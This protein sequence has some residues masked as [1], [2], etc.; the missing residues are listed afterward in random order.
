M[1]LNLPDHFGHGLANALIRA[2]VQA[3]EENNFVPAFVSQYEETYNAIM[4]ETPL[5]LPDN[6]WR[7]VANRGDDS[8]GKV[9]ERAG[10]IQA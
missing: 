8:V 9:L 10:Y 7:A 4:D 1:N 5:A 6:Y 3:I 2:G